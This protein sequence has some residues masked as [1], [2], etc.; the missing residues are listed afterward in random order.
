MIRINASLITG[1]ALALAQQAFEIA[2]RQFCPGRGLLNRQQTFLY[3]ADQCRQYAFRAACRRTGRLK[4]MRSVYS[5]T[6]KPRAQ[7]KTRLPDAFLPT[8]EKSALIQ[9]SLQYRSF[10]RTGDLLSLR[11]HTVYT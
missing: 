2:N 10:S 9:D 7:E 11:A 1:S 4:T 8:G 5:T 6:N 3:Q